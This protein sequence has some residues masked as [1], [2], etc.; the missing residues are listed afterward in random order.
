MISFDV[1]I[2]WAGTRLCEE[3]AL[4][5]GFTGG[6][7]WLLFQ[8]NSNASETHRSRG[9]TYTY[10]GI[11]QQPFVFYQL[12]T[13]ALVLTPLHVEEIRQSSCAS[14]H[15]STSLA[16]SFLS[17]GGCCWAYFYSI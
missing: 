10:S 12:L 15:T 4:A 13:M 2:C 1:P 9:D 11:P 7:E 5:F 14:S 16:M 6:V 8:R 3:T 17:C